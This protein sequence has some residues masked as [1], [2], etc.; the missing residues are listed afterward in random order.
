[1]LKLGIHFKYKNVQNGKSVRD[2]NLH[3]QTLLF[4]VMKTIFS[5]S[6]LFPLPTAE[7]EICCI[8]LKHFPNHCPKR[9]LLI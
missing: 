7:W 3:G 8:S 9:Y 5:F 6:F 4:P 2:F 1:M